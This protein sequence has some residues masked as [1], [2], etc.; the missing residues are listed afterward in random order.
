MGVHCVQVQ[1]TFYVQLIPIARHTAELFP[2]NDMNMYLNH[3]PHALHAANSNLI[4][5]PKPAG[6]DLM[7]A[8]ADV[9]AHEA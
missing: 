2:A 6:V 5:F 4:L 7:T 3:V 9:A 1:L 8:L